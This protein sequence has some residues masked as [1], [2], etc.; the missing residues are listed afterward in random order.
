MQN[1]HNKFMKKIKKWQIFLFGALIGIING[2]FGGGGG[3]VVV[4]L[5]NKMFGFEQKKAQATALFVILPISLV[6]TIVY[7]CFNSIAF[8]SG[9]P[10]ILGI[11]GG[12]VIGATLLNKLNN[13]VV[14]YIFI[15]FMLL[16]GVGMLIW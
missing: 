13:K 3:M 14:K 10:V 9:W 7:M 16:G 5:L 6:S 12:G 2:F 11:V 15:F 4:P 1:E 8:A